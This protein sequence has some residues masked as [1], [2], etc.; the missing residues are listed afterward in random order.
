MSEN[1][2]KTPSSF[3]LNF[4]S[5]M[6]TNINHIVQETLR[7]SKHKVESKKGKLLQAQIIKDCLIHLMQSIN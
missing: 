3:K 2:D 5:R 1:T 7:K 6:L 4:N